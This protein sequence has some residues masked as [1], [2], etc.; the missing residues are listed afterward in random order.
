MFHSTKTDYQL[1]RPAL[2]VVCVIVAVS[3]TSTLSP[4]TAQ[5]T[6]PELASQ[7]ASEKFGGEANLIREG[8]R[9]AD[10]PAVCRSSGE[11][12]L[13][14]FG[15]QTNPIVALENLASQRILKSVLDDSADDRWIVGG[16]ITEFQERNYVLL[17]R[18]IRQSKNK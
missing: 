3:A 14:S 8:T 7:V 9:I 18:V 10:L 6:N 13:V 1:G 16:Q 5:E 11:R 15:E 12:L 2:A 17:D 4:G